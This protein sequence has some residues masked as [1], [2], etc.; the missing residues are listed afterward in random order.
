M[1][2]GRAD[3]AVAVGSDAPATHGRLILLGPACS[4]TFHQALSMARAP[5][6][7]NL[8]NSCLG[9]LAPPHDRHKA[10]VSPALG[11]RARDGSDL[12]ALPLTV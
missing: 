5:T 4:V 12:G 9:D 1:F 8:S 2:R 11:P 6:S 10:Q 3:S 7:S